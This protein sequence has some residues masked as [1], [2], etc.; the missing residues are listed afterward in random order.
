MLSTRAG[1]LGLNLQT[2][3]TVIIFD[4]DWN[5][6]QDLQAQ[7]RAHRIGQ[8]NEVRVL[9]LLTVNSI[10]EGILE[11]ARF[12][13][14]IDSQ[15]IQAGKFNS[16]A[17]DNE[18]VEALRSI[19]SREDE[20]D[21]DA[22]H[23]GA[24]QDSG[25]PDAEHLNQMLA[26]GDDELELF[27]SMDLQMAKDDAEQ[28]MSETRKSRLMEMHEL[29]SWLNRDDAEVTLATTEKERVD[30]S[31]GRGRVRDTVK[32]MSYADI[33]DRQWER[34][35]EKGDA[36]EFMKLQTGERA[37][38]RPRV[39]D[40]PRRHRE[41]EPPKASGAG[42]M[43]KIIVTALLQAEGPSGRKICH[44][45]MK[46]PER[47]PGYQEKVKVKQDLWMWIDKVE[48]RR[49]K[50]RYSGSVEKLEKDVKLVCSNAKV[51]YGDGTEQFEDATRLEALFDSTWKQL[52]EEH[53]ASG[54]ASCA[55][56]TKDL[57]HDAP[58]AVPAL[59]P[60]D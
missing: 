22:E 23:E 60:D 3:D 21:H 30:L 48:L 41:R 26:R 11:T 1:G 8:K 35:V 38:K 28:W 55:P 47:L 53:E 54:E 12:K 40:P 43:A 32:D 17:N 27:N 50:G 36:D 2:A 29:P 37:A 10:E 24:E 57:P 7:D 39:D 34:A 6:H 31:L 4:S 5:P 33:S 16:A 15:V 25:L 56:D 49:S 44:S 14:N 20:D 42:Q 9:R 59:V 45:F 46:N 19:L 58:A 18:R 13:L 52:R 51:Y